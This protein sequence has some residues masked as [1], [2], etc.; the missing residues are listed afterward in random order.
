LHEFKICKYN[1]TFLRFESYRITN[2]YNTEVR[3]QIP[4]TSSTIFSFNKGHVWMDGVVLNVESEASLLA[5][6]K[7]EAPPNLAR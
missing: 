4:A 5:A 7:R 2:H 6:T 3:L 1:K